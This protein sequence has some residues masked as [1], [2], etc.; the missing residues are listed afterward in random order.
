MKV[1][2]SVSLKLRL[3]LSVKISRVGQLWLWCVMICKGRSKQLA[4]SKSCLKKNTNKTSIGW[5]AVGD[6]KHEETRR[7]SIIGPT[8]KCVITEGGIFCT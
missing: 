3:L 5:K 8:V 2:R 4:T 6:G 1:R 7:K